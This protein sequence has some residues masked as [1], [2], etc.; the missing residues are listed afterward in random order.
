MFK[1]GSLPL[2]GMV[3]E[4]DEEEGNVLHRSDG[5]EGKFASVEVGYMFSRS[6][7]HDGLRQCQ[8]EDPCSTS[9]LGTLQAGLV[10]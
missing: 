8:C 6:G 9:C 5:E 10:V 1:L 4:V 7:L 3:L 2:L